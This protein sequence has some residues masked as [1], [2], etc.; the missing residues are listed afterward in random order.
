MSNATQQSVT[1]SVDVAVRVGGLYTL[2]GSEAWQGMD[3]GPVQVE[4]LIDPAN[5]GPDT[6]M[7]QNMVGMFMEALDSLDDNDLG[8]SYRTGLWVQ[9]RHRATDTSEYLP[10]QLFAEHVVSWY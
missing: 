3:T 1:V 6:E 7:I 8:T 2:C 10:L 9:Y 5:P 4:A